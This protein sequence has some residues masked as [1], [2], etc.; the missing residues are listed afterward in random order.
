MV[1]VLECFLEYLGL[2]FQA[3]VKDFFA[4]LSVF[5]AFLAWILSVGIA[6]GRQPCLGYV[7]IDDL[8][9]M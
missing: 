3:N 5:L 8:G 2:T 6:K 1:R 9:H 7:K 4:A